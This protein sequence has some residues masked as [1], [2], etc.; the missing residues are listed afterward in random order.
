[1]NNLKARQSVLSILLIA[2]VANM[3]C[4]QSLAQRLTQRQGL[5]PQWI[6]IDDFETGNLTGWIKAD[7]KNE[8]DPLLPKPQITEIRAEDSGNRF[9]IKK[10]AKDGVVGNRKALTYKKLP[11]PIPAGATYTI[12]SRFLVE[13]FPNN[14]VFGLS[15]LPPKEIEL[16]DYNAFEPTLRVTDKLESDG[17]RNTGA[18]MVRTGS[19]YSNVQNYAR[20]RS[21][22]P[23]QPGI[24]YQV[25]WVV[26]NANLAE[27]GQTYDVYLKGG[28]FKQQVKVFEG[29]SFRMKRTRP[30]Q[31]FLMN[32][33]TGPIDAPYGNGG[34]A[35]D[36]LYMHKGLSLA[37]PPK[38]T[39]R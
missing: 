8:T 3:I 35:Y 17:T 25:W 7:T 33:N 1:M 24:W 22:E 9:L 18:L 2:I 31:Y 34:L 36:D 13:E 20:Q 16:H 27:G 15:N 37:I 23:L 10:P 28:E 11:I 14:H 4:S 38:N 29:A 19:G 26:N 12:Y 5:A 21:S 6:K 30:I 39:L 32:C